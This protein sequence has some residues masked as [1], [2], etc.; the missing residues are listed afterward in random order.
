MLGWVSEYL[1]RMP[2]SWGEPLF[3]DDGLPTTDT[4]NGEPLGEVLENTR[5]LKQW[6]TDIW[7][8]PENLQE[9]QSTLPAPERV[10]DENKSYLEC[11][12]DK[13][14]KPAA[15][16]IDDVYLG[17]YSNKV[18]KIIESLPKISTHEADLLYDLIS[19]IF[20]YQPTQRVSARDILAHPWFHMDDTT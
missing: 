17:A 2:T 5:S 15:I 14:W 9:L 18:D 3:D 20:V 12:R 10:K 1:G 19:K 8:Q 4:T 11:Y 6:I 16:R 13:F 7:Y